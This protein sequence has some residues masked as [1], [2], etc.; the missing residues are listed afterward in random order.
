MDIKVF[1]DTDDDIRFIR[2]LQRDT[3]TRGRTVASVVEQ[4]IKTVI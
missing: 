2:R 1:V 4:Y 3:E